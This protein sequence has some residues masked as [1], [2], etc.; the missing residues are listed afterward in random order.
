MSAFA[1]VELLERAP[2]AR[3]SGGHLLLVDPREQQ[4]VLE[5]DRVGD[6]PGAFV[7]DLLFRLGT[8]IRASGPN[9]FAIGGH[10]VPISMLAGTLSGP[11]Q[12]CGSTGARRDGA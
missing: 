10:N 7:P 5:D 12:Q 6:Q 8:V 1:E 4:S 2:S 3:L 11:P 9:L